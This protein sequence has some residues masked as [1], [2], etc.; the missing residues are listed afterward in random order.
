MN[1]WE[2]HCRRVIHS[3]NPETYKNCAAY[4]QIVNLGPRALPFVRNAYAGHDDSAFF[5]FGGWASVVQD[6]V[7]AT[8]QVPNGI[9]GD[10]RRIRD[11][12]VGFL[13]HYLHSSTWD[14]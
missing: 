13:D 11:Y 8:F 6:I 2:R 3:S 9:R 10:A 5:S 1:D 14:E 4:R 12:T 7:G